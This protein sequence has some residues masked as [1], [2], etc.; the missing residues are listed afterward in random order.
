MADEQKAAYMIS[1]YQNHKTERLKYQK[2]YRQS[3]KFEIA[4]YKKAYQKI[5]QKAYTKR[6]CKTLIGNL[7]HR[8][9]QIKER[10]NN[11]KTVGYKYWGGRGIKCLFK[12]ANEFIDYVTNDLGYDTIEKLKKL[13][14]DRIDNDGHYEKGNIRFVTAKENCNNRQKR[15]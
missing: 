9:R 5:H 13:Q 10:C 2:E 8:F 1:Y 11:P 6:Y 7:R 12:S 15:Y 4:E 14:I 3:H